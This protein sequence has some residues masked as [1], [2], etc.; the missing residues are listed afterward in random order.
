M[1][2]EEFVSLSLLLVTKADYFVCNFTDLH[3][4]LAIPINVFTAN[5]TLTLKAPRK[6]MHLKMS[7]VEVVCCK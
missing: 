4:T 3:V 2:M 5:R 1:G 6:K 7:S